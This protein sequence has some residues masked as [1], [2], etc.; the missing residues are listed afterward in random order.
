VWRPLI[1][2]RF[3][4]GTR[5]HGGHGSGGRGRGRGKSDENTSTY[6]PPSEWNA[7]SPQQRQTFLQAQAAS[8]INAMTSIIIGNR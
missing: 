3:I 1:N 7:M 8:R 5:S 2:P 6:I 4:R